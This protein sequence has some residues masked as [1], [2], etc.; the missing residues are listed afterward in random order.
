MINY[1]ILI[2]PTSPAM[3][4]HCLIRDKLS[5]WFFVKF[6]L[7]P[8]LKGE[9]GWSE[10]LILMGKSAVPSHHYVGRTGCHKYDWSARQCRTYLG[11]T[12]KVKHQTG[13]FQITTLVHLQGT[14]HW[15]MYK[16]SATTDHSYLTHGISPTILF[17]RC[18]PSGIGN[19][20]ERPAGVNLKRYRCILNT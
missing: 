3:W 8:N 7:S 15:S 13:I 6:F 5:K 14:V 12:S 16:S 17:W 20:Q 10:T 19:S 18:Q 1:Q 11:S 2:L 4:H 9:L